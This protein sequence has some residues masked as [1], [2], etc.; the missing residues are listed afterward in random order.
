MAQQEGRLVYGPWESFT[1]RGLPLRE[2]DP[3]D[4]L[5]G[6]T[7]IAGHVHYEA[8]D[9]RWYCDAGLMSIPLYDGRE[10]RFRLEPVPQKQGDE[11]DLMLATLS[12]LGELSDEEAWSEE[13]FEDEPWD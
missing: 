4:I 5:A 8:S 9:A 3:L 10:A 6:N 1:L 12:E 11:E 7:W 13:E 2:G